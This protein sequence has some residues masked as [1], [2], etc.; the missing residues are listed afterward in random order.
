MEIDFLRR[1]EKAGPISKIIS[2]RNFVGFLNK[3]LLKLV[4]SKSHI[5]VPTPLP[6]D[7]TSESGVTLTVYF[8]GRLRC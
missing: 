6:E 7:S 1:S 8:L 5:Q 2:G 4:G 3:L